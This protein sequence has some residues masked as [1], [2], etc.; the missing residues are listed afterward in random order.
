MKHS[1]YP[2]YKKSGVEWLGDVPKHWDVKQA[3]RCLLEHKQGYYTTDAYVADGLKLLRITD[4]DGNGFVKTEDCPLVDIKDEA[5]PFLLRDND[6]VFARTGGAGSFGLVKSVKERIV[7]ASYLIR[8]RFNNQTLADFLR[9]SFLSKQFVHGIVK[10]IHGGVNQ[11]VHA[12]DIKDQFIPLPPLSEQQTIAA[13][14]DRETGRI[15]SLIDKKH[16]LIELLKEKRTAL[17]SRAVTKGLN[18]KVKMKPSGVEWLG[19]VPEHWEVKKTR[20][21]FS[22]ISGGTPST[23]EPDYWSGDVPWVSSKD[24]KIFYIEDT[25][26]HISPIAVKESA[27]N[28]IPKNTLLLVMRS[29]ILQHTIPACVIKRR[30][31]INQDIKAFIPK[32][33][34]SSAYYARLIEGNQKQLLTKLRKEGATVESL[35]ME[36][37]KNLPIPLPPL[38]E[39]QTIAAFLDRET[40]KIDSLVAK[41]EMVIEKLKEYRT[42]LISTAVTGKIDVSTMLNTGVAT[43][44][45]TGVR[46]VA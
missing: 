26:D 42:A 19:D 9:Y 17:I 33:P 35:D 29:G 37:I 4:L 7:F 11:N 21:L 24:M 8:F 20:F 44:R 39:Q 43:G 27:T 22:F 28:V 14:L 16:K 5:T 12:E 38:P 34:V 15:D 36:L 18:P 40:S 31:A 45:N 30:M 3:R 10:N 46:E 41:V 25:E 32:V 13:F 2:K 23:E 1:A 6:F